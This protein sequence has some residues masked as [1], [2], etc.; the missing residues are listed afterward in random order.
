VKVGVVAPTFKNN[1]PQLRKKM[2]KFKISYLHSENS[3]DVVAQDH[4]L[5]GDWVVFKD[6]CGTVLRMRASGIESITRV[7]S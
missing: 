5:D 4:Y 2:A 1:R 6:A 7:D 3:E